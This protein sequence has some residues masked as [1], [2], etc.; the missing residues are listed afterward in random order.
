MKLSGLDTRNSSSATIGLSNCD[1]KIAWLS[2]GKNDQVIFFLADLLFFPKDL[3]DLLSG[4]IENEFNIAS[5]NLVFAGTHTH[6][7]PELGFTPAASKQSGYIQE[8]YAKICVRMTALQSELSEASMEQ[9]TIAAPKVSINRRKVIRH[10]K[11]N[12]AKKALML[13]NPE[14]NSADKIKLIKFTPAEGNPT[15]FV[16]Y[17][18]HPVFNRNHS[19]SSDYPGRLSELC[20]ASLSLQEVFCFQ[21]FGGDIRPDFR[22]KLGIKGRIKEWL[23]GP[24]FADYTAEHF[25]SFC[26]QLSQSIEN[27][28]AALQPVVDAEL[29][30]RDEA[31]VL[32]SQ[33]GKTKKTLAIK[34]IRLGAHQNWLIANAELFCKYE[35]LLG[36]NF[37]TIGCAAGAIGY[38][39]DAAALPWGGYEVEQAAL[40]NGL[41]APFAR[42]VLKE[43]ETF[44]SQ[45][46]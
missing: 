24:E 5:N 33:S 17:P 28:Q 32:R 20:A 18:S 27:G 16:S 41:D 46:G 22:G 26:Q 14:G 19:I 43:L 11:T 1:L 30:I 2:F 45:L 42:K 38:V 25:E 44:L 3:A 39:P 21:G 31:F 7:A 10:W 13:P 4:F 12:F 23:H 40:N 35:Q 9:A 34:I 15:L 6:S 36:D 29:Q 8:Q 37:F